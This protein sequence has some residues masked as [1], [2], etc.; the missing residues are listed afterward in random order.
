MIGVLIIP[1]G[2]GAEIGGHAGDGNPVAKLLAACCETLITHPNVVNASD[3]NEMPENVLYV[4]G[5]MLDRFLEGKLQ[6][7]PTKTYNKILLVVNS[8]IT[9]DTINAANSARVTIGADIEILELKEPLRMKA[10]NVGGIATGIVAGWKELV[11]QVDNLAFDA[12][13]IHTPI[14]VDRGIALGYFLN[15]GINPWGGVE[16]KASKLIAN[17]LNKPVA[18]APLESESLEE[19]NLI[20]KMDIDPRVAPE[21]ISQCYLH[22]VLK[23]L[24]RAPRMGRG[25]SAEDVD[26]MVSPYGCFDRSHIACL[27][28]DIPVIVVRENKTC[29][30]YKQS[31]EEFIFVDNYLEAAGLIMSMKAGVTVDSIR[32]PLKE[33][34]IK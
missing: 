13:A 28:N 31:V 8:P 33:L 27:G 30:D 7:K 6:L 20:S 2:I 17:E 25:L 32:R 24:H 18:H 14:E 22:C 11:A 12:L 9:K 5:S 16:A 10:Q 29:L 3:I 4:E 21:V 1:T 19:I 34:I 26:F 23:G 15:G